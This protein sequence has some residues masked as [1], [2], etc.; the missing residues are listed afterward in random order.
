MSQKLEFSLSIIDHEGLMILPD[1]PV[2][3]ELGLLSFKG[4]KPFAQGERFIR[5]SLR[6]LFNCLIEDLN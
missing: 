4:F 2:I 5:G 6:I 3:I 1:F